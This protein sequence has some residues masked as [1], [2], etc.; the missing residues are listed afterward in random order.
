MS[1]LIGSEGL[2]DGTR[3]DYIIK[4]SLFCIMGAGANWVF[5]TALIQ[6]VPYFEDSLP[7]GVC[8][9]AYMNAVTNIG[10]FVMLFYLWYI[11]S[12]R[13]IPHS[14]SVPALL[15]TSAVA[16]F[17]TA[18]VYP[19]HYDGVSY[20]LYLCCA[21]GGCVGALSSVIMGAF[22]SHYHNDC[23]SAGRVGG[24]G[25]ILLTALLALVQNP[26]S[27][28]RRFASSIYFVIFGVILL[29]PIAAYYYIVG[30]DIG[31]RPPQKNDN[32]V[33]I[34]SVNRSGSDGISLVNIEVVP[35]IESFN[36]INGGRISSVK[37]HRSS[38]R[39]TT[40]SNS[41]YEARNS[42]VDT[43]I[44]SASAANKDSVD[45]GSFHK[46]PTV[47]LSCQT[48]IYYKVKDFFEVIVMNI[49]DFVVTDSVHKKYPWFRQALPYM[50]T[51]GW[52]NFNTWGMVTALIPFAVKNIS[53]GSGSTN[54][55]VAYQLGAALLVSGDFS[56]V[57][58]KMPFF[59]GLILFTVF[60]CI[61]YIASSNLSEIQTPAAAPILIVVFALERFIEAHLVTS[62]YRCIA[63]FFPL[64]Y[65]ETASRAVGFCD[66]LFTTLGAIVS[67]ILVATV[68]SC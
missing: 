39:S 21:L 4:F 34:D 47:V 14:Y 58:F 50:L 12:V 10:F 51:V 65:R 23:I 33:S 48:K 13:F 26:G 44:G 17:L 68:L 67:T 64:A 29:F 53:K 24:S 45:F 57:F 5:P 37:S 6:Q 32:D 22:L 46:P 15:V 55:A 31:I 35:T 60:C 42:M 20:M 2:G 36:P 1:G 3:L 43:I 61:V 7:E 25:F 16:C 40:S 49:C 8:I 62:V 30:N 19:I 56:T 52:V 38:N 27:D 18:G 54:L 28:N 11:N 41:N 59:I 66:Q 63:T 9:A